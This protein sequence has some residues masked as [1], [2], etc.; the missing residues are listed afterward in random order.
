M[1]AGSRA[2]RRLGMLAL[3]GAVPAGWGGLQQEQVWQGKKGLLRALGDFP[4]QPHRSAS[5]SAGTLL[6]L[7][8]A[9]P[10]VPRAAE[11]GG[12]KD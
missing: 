1:A 2:S 8:R 11:P 6:L 3:T 9:F 12:G 10:A 7:P 5:T 4:E